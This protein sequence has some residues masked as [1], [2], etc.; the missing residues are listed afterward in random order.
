MGQR[1]VKGSEVSATFPC[2]QRNWYSLGAGPGHKLTG[3]SGP[4]CAPSETTSQQHNGNATQVRTLARYRAGSHAVIVCSPLH[5]PCH[6]RAGTLSSGLNSHQVPM[7]SNSSSPGGL[8]VQRALISFWS[9][10][11]QCHQH[12]TTSQCSPLPLSD[13]HCLPGQACLTL[14][15]YWKLPPLKKPHSLVNAEASLL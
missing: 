9:Y 14:I 8:E 4:C 5:P 13:P 10:L 12:C 3:P 15:P 11:L 1:S 7:I 2:V 6:H